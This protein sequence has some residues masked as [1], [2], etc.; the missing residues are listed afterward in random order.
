MKIHR[1]LR[2]LYSGFLVLV[3]TCFVNFHGHASEESLENIA[4]RIGL[5]DSTGYGKGV[6]IVDVDGDGWEDIWDLNTNIL[7]GKDRPS[8][9]KLYLNQQ[10]GTFKT[11][12]TGVDPLDVQFAWGA[13]WADFDNDGDPDLVVAS[14]GLLRKGRLALYENRWDD[15]KRLKSISASAGITAEGHGWWGASWADFDKLDFDNDG[16]QDLYLAG[17]RHHRLYRND[18]DRG[19]IDVTERLGKPLMDR[20][21]VFAAFASDLNHDG[22]ID[23]YL[24]RRARQELIAF[25]QPDGTF[26]ISGKDVGIV[27]KLAPDVSENTM[28]LGAGDINDDGY[29]DIMIGTGSPRDALHDI[30]F[31][32]EKKPDSPFGVTFKRCG[33]FVKIGHGKKQTHGIAVGDLDQDG[34][35]DVFYN[36]GGAPPYDLKNGTDSRAFNALYSKRMANEKTAAVLLKGVDSNR[37]A[38][39]ARIKVTVSPGNQFHY[40]IRSAQGFQ[41]ENSRWQ[42]VT[43]MNEERASIEIRWPSGRVTNHTVEAGDRTIIQER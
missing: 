18:G 5:A 30:V 41:S 40:E 23:L 43:L 6:S 4:E 15:E 42:L 8:N 34:S 10:D 11:V 32:G 27:T 37:D 13:A 28:G 29:V 33:D 9:S 3:M 22:N 35:N 1:L 25:G 12:E 38:I 31:C 39:G 20:P 7:R 17:I 24:G 16:D 26:K 36:L 2:S 19:F 21:G 14:G